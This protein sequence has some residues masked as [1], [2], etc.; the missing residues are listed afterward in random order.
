MSNYAQNKAQ[1][2]TVTNDPTM[3]DQSQAT[4]TDINV[5][6]GRYGIGPLAMGTN[7]QGMTGDFSQLPE[8]LRGFIDMGR[9][10]ETL[11]EKLPPELQNKSVEEIVALTPEQ[12]TNILNPSPP[13][14]PTENEETSK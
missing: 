11:R 7:K 1:S 13:S 14:A 4:D 9:S 10:I 8:D 5:I 3:T 12:L 2:M 6:V